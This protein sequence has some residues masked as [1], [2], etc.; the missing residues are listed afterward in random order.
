MTM[1][2]RR[3]LLGGI[4]GAAALF[5]GCSEITSSASGSFTETT[6]ENQQLIVEFDESLDAET[7]SVIDPD[8]ESFAE[9]SVAAGASRVTFDVEMPY[10]PGGYRIIATSDGETLAETTQEIQPEL[11][12]VDVGIGANRLDEMPES[13]GHTKDDEAVLEVLNSG[14]GPERISKLQFHGDLPNPTTPEGDRAG[15]Y[16]PESRGDLYDTLTIN[17]GDQVTIFSSTMPFSFEG[18]G[19]ECSA[20]AKEGE[21]VVEIEGA[22]TG[23]NSRGYL[24]RYTSSE[25]YD[26]CEIPLIEA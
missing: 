18:D 3:N 15:I 7:I 8:G 22:V 14:S 16:D 9:A 2:T 17:S 10:T 12:I 24:V 5:A 21:A 1:H 20:E 6:V 23:E 4:V 13:L 19:V 11:E 26:G 25:S